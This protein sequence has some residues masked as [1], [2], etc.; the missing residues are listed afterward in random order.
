MS[1]FNIVFLVISIL[2]IVSVLLQQRGSGL[3]EAFGGTGSSYTSRR[4][5]E[6]FLYNLTIILSLLFILMGGINLYQKRVISLPA[7]EQPAAEQL[8]ED[9]PTTEESTETAPNE[10]TTE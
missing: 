3:G 9:Q 7:T 6:R 1:V 2:L 5:A 8:T 4:G 10:P